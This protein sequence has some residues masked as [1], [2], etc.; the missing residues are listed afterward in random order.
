MKE[1]RLD[2]RLVLHR[3]DELPPQLWKVDVQM[4]KLEPGKQ[5][6]PPGR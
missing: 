1:S 2:N 6:T 4:G 5:V 3:Y